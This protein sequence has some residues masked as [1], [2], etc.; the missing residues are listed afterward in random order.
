MMIMTNKVTLKEQIEGIAFETLTAEQ[1]D[2]LR[3]RALKSIRK[4]ST[5]KGLTKAQKENIVLAEKVV[6]FVAEKG[7]VTIKDVEDFLNVSNQKA[8]AIL[9]IAVANGDLTKTEAKGK[10]KATFTL[11]EVEDEDEVE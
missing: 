10:Q 11:A 4:A 5:K 8:T 7:V 6:D 2:F 3:E 1:F 9:K